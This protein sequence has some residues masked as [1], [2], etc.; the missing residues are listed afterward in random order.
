M[1]VRVEEQASTPWGY[2]AAVEGLKL[3]VWIRT[4]FTLESEREPEGL[5]TRVVG[6]VLSGQKQDHV[7][8]SKWVFFFLNA[9][10][11]LRFRWGDVS[12]VR[13]KT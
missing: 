3:N 9:R 4:C 7:F 10:A 11:R 6:T 13:S 12:V 1:S 8:M 5:R 2:T